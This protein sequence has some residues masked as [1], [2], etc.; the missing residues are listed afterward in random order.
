MPYNVSIHGPEALV[1]NAN[2]CTQVLLLSKSKLKD[3][4]IEGF[5]QGAAGVLAD[6]CE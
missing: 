1:R 2:P 4:L 5:Q 3:T 6:L